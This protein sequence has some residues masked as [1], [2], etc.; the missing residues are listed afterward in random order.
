LKKII[1]LGDPVKKTFME[2]ITML[3][4]NFTPEV[5][6]ISERYKFWKEVQNTGQ[7]MFGYL[8]ELKVK[9]QKFLTFLNQAL[10]DWLVS[11]VRDDKLCV[12]LLKEPKLSFQ[13]ACAATI[14]WE[15]AEKEVKGQTMNKFAVRKNPIISIK[16]GQDQKVKI[17][18]MA[19][20][21]GVVGHMIVKKSVQS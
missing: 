15:L 19:S 21:P 10:R 6:E 8:V 9:A 2:L 20:V 13:S 1:F 4:I 7:P 11:G 16:T 18:G 12:L 3:K 17:K 14:N 5:N